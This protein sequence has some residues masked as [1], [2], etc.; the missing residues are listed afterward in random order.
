[1]F[2]MNKKCMPKRR[3]T[4]TEKGKR[5]KYVYKQSV[6]VKFTQQCAQSETIASL[7]DQRSKIRRWLFKVEDNAYF[8]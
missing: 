4:S 3:S 7:D 1:M 5:T 2:Q 6:S 8:V